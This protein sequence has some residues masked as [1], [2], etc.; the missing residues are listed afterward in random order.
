MISAGWTLIRVCV[1]AFGECNEDDPSCTNFESGLTALTVVVGFMCA[2]FTMFCLSFKKEEEFTLQTA[3]I[4][5]K[6][7]KNLLGVFTHVKD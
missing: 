5:R 1:A 6:K 4:I 7:F 2:L 3:G